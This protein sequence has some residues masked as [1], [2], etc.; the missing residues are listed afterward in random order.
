MNI[1]LGRVEFTIQLY[2]LLHALEQQAG[3]NDVDTRTSI[4]LL[5][6]K[7]GEHKDKYHLK[8]LRTRKGQES[9]GKGVRAGADD[10]VSTGA[11]G[12]GASATD[13]E[14][15]RAHGYEV[16]PVI[17]DSKGAAFEPLIEVWRPFC[18]YYTLL[19]LVL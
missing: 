12:G 13:S 7:T 5:N 8:S 4:R 9:K 10:D 16:K 3:E 18:A 15:L 6:T 17:V 19:T 1:S 11:G 14:D 2:N